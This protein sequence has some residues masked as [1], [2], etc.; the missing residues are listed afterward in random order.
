MSDTS[1]PMFHQYKVLKGHTDSINSLVFSPDGKQLASGGDD[2]CLFVFNT[3]TWRTER[4][5]RTVSPV[6]AVTWHDDYPGAISFGLKT[7]I[8]TTV[9][10]K[11]N[12]KFEHNVHGT[13]HCM[14]SDR[15]L[16]AVGFNNEVLIARLSSLS[17]WKSDRHVPRPADVNGIQDITRSLNFHLKEK[18]IFVT[19][20]FAG[21]MAYDIED[22]A[23]QRWRIDLRGLCG[24]SALSPTGRLLATTMILGG[25]YWS[26]TSKRTVASITEQIQDNV[27]V[28]LPI[29]FI[30]TNTVAVGSPDGQVIICK[31][32]KSRAN[33]VLS[34]NDDMVQTLA[35]FHQKHDSSHL[36]VTGISEMN[37]DCV[38]TIWKAQ[39]ERK[40]VWLLNAVCGLDIYLS[41]RTY[42]DDSFKKAIMAY[43]PFRIW[44]TYCWTFGLQIC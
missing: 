15:K 9:Q 27:K 1:I 39:E 24:E 28:Q 29:V 31:S 37:E 14:A 34:H 4:K 35:Y 43:P 36:L 42:T 10:L 26:D 32:G 25:I 5:Y 38:L 33:Q 16:L 11:D 20:M 8:V 23:I 19:Y 6:R 41:I 40:S 44:S 30:S 13:I 3:R 12:L 18:L 17:S 7:G 22:V 21:I 2:G